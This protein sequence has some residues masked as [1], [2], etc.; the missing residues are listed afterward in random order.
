MYNKEVIKKLSIM[1]DKSKSFLNLTIIIIFAFTCMLF[2]IFLSRSLLMGAAFVS[3]V[4]YITILCYRP[5]YVTLLIV[6]TLPFGP[7][8]NLPFTA[9]GFLLSL[10]LLFSAFI[11]HVAKL[12]FSKDYDLIYYPIS[13]KVHLLILLFLFV[14]ILSCI[15][16]YYLDSSILYIKRFIYCLIIYYY[17]SY[18]I[19]TESQLKLAIY[20]LVCSYCII[21]ILGIVEILTGTRIYEFLN[22]KSLFGSNV[23]PDVLYL[24]EAGRLSGTMGNPEFHSFRMVSFFFILAFP[25]FDLKSRILKLTLFIP[26]VLSVIN[27]L[28]AAFRGAM[29][30]LLVSL[31]IFFSLSKLQYK[32]IIMLAVILLLIIIGCS[33]YLLVPDLNIERLVETEKEGL[34]TV[35]MRKNNTLIGLKMGFDHPIIGHGPNG[36]Y[37]QY[38][39]YA[40]S[41][42]S[43]R[44]EE[45]KTHNTYAQV[46]AEHGSIGL[47]VFVLII[48]ITLK[49]LYRNMKSSDNSSYYL[50]LSLIMGVILHAGFMAGSN[51]LIDHN[52]WLIM[53]LAG[54]AERVYSYQIKDAN[55]I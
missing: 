25:Y 39:R 35:Q 53:A 27:I 12:L 24:S 34:G 42:P 33:I 23:P 6:F 44:P 28:G 11:Y 26:L 1:P 43:A 41:F 37:L 2:G 46:F 50:L 19:K 17:M 47:L 13:K 31:I 20:V 16:S 14:M 8:L 48:A 22:K 4:I 51:V 38:N 45:I 29:A 7:I 32:Y 52:F 40:S 18:L 30:V 15:N 3:T 55:V 21:S 54:A 36:F 9:D 49:N 10:A 5:F